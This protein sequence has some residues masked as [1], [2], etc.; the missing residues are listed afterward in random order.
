MSEQLLAIA[1]PICGAQVADC[2]CFKDAGHVDAG[3]RIHECDPHRCTGAWI[4]VEP[5]W[6]PARIPFPVYGP[7]PSG[8]ES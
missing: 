6:R 3:D 2:C 5:G 8:E 7:P 4:G 1:R